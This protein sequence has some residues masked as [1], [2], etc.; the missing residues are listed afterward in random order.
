[1][2]LPAPS[3]ASAHLGLSRAEVA[4]REAAGLVNAVPSGPSRTLV[5]IIRANVFT[6]FNLLL[7]ALL[8]LVLVVAPIQDALFGVVL[9]TNSAI[10]ILQE[11]R[12]KRTLDR[13]ALL[14]A[15]RALVVRDGREVDLA[16]DRVVLDDLLV[17]RPGDQ[18]VVDGEVVATE[19]LEVNES[20]LTGESD[21][22]LKEPGESVLSGSFVSS[23]A[24]RYRATRVGAEAYA[25]RIAEEAKRFTLVRSELRNG[26]NRLLAVIGWTMIPTV[27]LLVWSQVQL[28]DHVGIKE[29]LRGTAAGI[30]AMVPEGLVL[31][32]SVAFAV[33]VVRLG[34]RRVLVQELPAV[35]GLAR[36]DVVCFDKTGTLT[37]GRLAVES[38]EV[39]DEKHD[40]APALG[41]L[42]ASDR[43]PNAT[44]QAIA[45]AFPAPAAGWRP[46]AAVPF[47]SARK[48]SGASF[49]GT[50]SWVLGA[51]EMILPDD[52]LIAASL[53]AAASRGHRVLLLARGSGPLAPDTLPPGLEP[54]ALVGLTDRVRPDAAQTLRY[55]AAQ[56]VAAKVISGDHPQT[57]AAIAAQVGLEGADRVVDARTLPEDPEAL[58]EVL[59][60]GTVFGRVTPHQKRAMVAA[61]QSRGHV[62][63][64]TG[65]GVND[66]LALKDADIGIAMGS[67]AAASRA[68]AQL[69][70]L[71]GSFA[72]LPSVVAEGRRVISNIERVANLFLTKTVYAFLLAILVGLFSRPFPFVPRHLTLVGSL[73]I[74]IPA[75][76][77]ALAPSAQRARPG[78][79]RRVVSF[80]LPV[81]TLAAAA[82]YCA[83]ELAIFEGIGLIEARTLAALVLVSIGLF[84]LVINA[85]P[86]TPWR[87]LLIGGMAAAFLIVLASNRLRHFFE[88]DLP[89]LVVLL[90]GVGIVGLTGGILYGALRAVGWAQQV[91]DMLRSPKGEG[92]VVPVLRHSVAWLRERARRIGDPLDPG[93]PPEPPG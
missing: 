38:L 3:P 83:Y 76:F 32:T 28:G 80:A 74:G 44:L 53:E 10:G 14:N 90:A 19:G 81:G 52:P 7:G 48:W 35:E 18:I 27:T 29:A 39:L 51:P 55:F 5:Q 68:V 30:V 31:L 36:V 78:F 58:A 87:R 42:A 50:G 92:G 11:L 60:Q 63:A 64:M 91:P 84:A 93:L 40:P 41:A 88:L 22:I 34:R 16:V 17:L 69:V 12:A 49:D 77:L 61:L 89:P 59:E 46:S 45:D 2:T 43:N 67:G 20:L 33:G 70:L 71:D 47:S 6:V 85:R 15:P 4:E 21:P 65:D 73:T 1:M 56:G 62:V 75:F 79:V 26:I 86:L 72:T 13:L 37:E 57:V 66:A 25:A 24:G 8:V 54:V 9:I 82:T 23:G